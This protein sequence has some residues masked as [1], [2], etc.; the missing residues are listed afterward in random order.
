MVL[1]RIVN[2][3]YTA[4]L[5]ISDDE[6]FSFSLRNRVRNVGYKGDIIELESID[7]AEDYFKGITSDF[8]PE[9]PKDPS[10]LVILDINARK[11]NCF[12]LLNFHL[13]L[14]KKMR[15]RFRFVIYSDSHDCKWTELALMYYSVHDIGLK[16]NVFSETPLDY[17][18]SSSKNKRIEHPVL[19][20]T[21]SLIKFFSHKIQSIFR[22]L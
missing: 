19:E 17:F 18:N 2:D 11:L 12:R 10:F 4:L 14:P 8:L 3:C 1:Q 13:T 15:E 21:M 6:R 20:A 5:L 9:L 7:G 16:E 22:I